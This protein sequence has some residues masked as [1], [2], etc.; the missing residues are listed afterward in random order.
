M[1]II[2][3]LLLIGH[4]ARD[5]LPRTSITKLS[6]YENENGRAIKDNKGLILSP[7]IM[8]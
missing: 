5:S 4:C 7:V 3:F 6:A 2:L 8:Q 1:V